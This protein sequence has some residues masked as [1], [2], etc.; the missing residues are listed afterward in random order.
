MKKSVISYLKKLRKRY[1]FWKERRWTG[2]Y[3]LLIL[4]EFVDRTKVAVD[5]GGNIG[6][7]TYW[8][9]KF[10]TRVITFEPNPLYIDQI[11]NLRLP[12]VT[13]EAV[14]LSDRSG[15]AELRIPRSAG[16]HE[17]QGMASIDSKAVSDE[18]L[19][20]F[21]EV[22]TKR[23]D[24]YELG[25]VGFIKIDVE[26]HEE[27]VL[28]GARQTLTRWKPVVLVEVEEVR[29]PG[30]IGRI[31]E[32]MSS[33]GYVGHYY[34]NGVKRPIETFDVKH[35]QP[36]NIVWDKLKYTRRTFPVVNN[37]IFLPSV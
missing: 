30:S 24:D 17:D 25:Q 16:G 19:S 31:R 10:A 33:L 6:S 26:G 5:I 11:Q 8:L 20:R 37:F 28:E 15:M 14:A 9:S 29:N 21:L 35:H 32:L 4:P 34:E 23:L 3:E 7:Y 13:S 2:E 27:A 1:F 36:N 12:N 18:T 22:P